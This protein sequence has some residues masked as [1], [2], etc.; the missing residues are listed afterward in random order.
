MI[1]FF[2]TYP[3]SSLGIMVEPPTARAATLRLEGGHWETTAFPRR[4]FGGKKP[5]RATEADSSNGAGASV[6][7][8]VQSGEESTDGCPVGS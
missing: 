3:E 4:L 7:G 8:R 2:G 6:T 5:V 1:P